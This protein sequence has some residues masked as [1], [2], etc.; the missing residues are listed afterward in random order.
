M[1]VQKKTPAICMCYLVKWH[2]KT[3]DNNIDVKFLTLQMK[4]HGP[5]NQNIMKKYQG[6][7]LL[8]LDE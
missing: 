6:S 2:A 3:T 8:G 7:S 5:C 4:Y 1:S